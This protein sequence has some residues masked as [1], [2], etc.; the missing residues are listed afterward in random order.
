MSTG[1]LKKSNEN[2]EEKFIK[3]LSENNILFK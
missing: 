1:F 2:Y 3:L